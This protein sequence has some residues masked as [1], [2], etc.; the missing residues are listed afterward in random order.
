MNEA[1]GVDSHDPVRGA[2]RAVPP[3]AKRDPSA[4]RVP[5]KMHR[6]AIVLGILPAIA[7]TIG[8]LGAHRGIHRSQMSVSVIAD[9]EFR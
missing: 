2:P 7:A 4:G 5:R 1:E 3:I 6:A 8:A 9:V